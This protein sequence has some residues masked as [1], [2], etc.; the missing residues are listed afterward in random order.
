[1]V[2]LGVKGSP[3]FLRR[4]RLDKYEDELGM[5]GMGTGG[6]VGTVLD[7]VAW[8][9]YIGVGVGGVEEGDMI[10]RTV[11]DRMAEVRRG[12]MGEGGAGGKPGFER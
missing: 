3:F 9:G 6:G 7:E 4:F 11:R 5:E 1:M 12:W 2:S 8:P 10:V